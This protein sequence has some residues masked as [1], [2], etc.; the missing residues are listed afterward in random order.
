MTNIDLSASYYHWSLL[1]LLRRSTELY[2][3]SNFR[4]KL[5]QMLKKER[6]YIFASDLVNT[7]EGDFILRA[8]RTYI[9]ARDRAA[10]DMRDRHA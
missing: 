5:Q 9:R 3:P 2:L 1:I 7:T 4:L 6:D 8:E 10:E